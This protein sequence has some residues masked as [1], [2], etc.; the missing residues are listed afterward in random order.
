MFTTFRL[1]TIVAA[2][3]LALALSSVAQG[4]VTTDVTVLDGSGN[5][6]ADNVRSFDENEAGSGLAAG[7]TPQVGSTF[8]FLY[9]SN[10]V[11]FNS[12]AGQPITPSSGFNA[13]F[14]SGGYEF[15]VVA[16]IQ[17]TVT[18]VSMVNGITT[19]TFEATGG[20]ASIFFDNVASGGAKSVTSTGVGFDDGHR[21]GLFDVVGGSGLGTFTTFPDGTALGATSYDFVVQPSTSVDSAYIAGLLGPIGGLHFTSSQVLPPG[22]S[23]ASDFH[24]GTPSNAPDLYASTAVGTNLLLKVDGSNT[25]STAIPEPETYALM[26]AGLGALSFM[27]RPRRGQAL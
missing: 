27:T 6:I 2:G 1:T 4:Q 7:F 3:A 10:V 20:T 9:Q 8:A 17:E 25:F 18:S 13:P 26:L 5:T 14:A 19:V 23:F 15:T 21:V 22:T 24:V 11:G 16:R 12:A